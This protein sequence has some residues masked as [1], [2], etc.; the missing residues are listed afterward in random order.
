[1][2]QIKGNSPI[3]AGKDLIKLRGVLYVVYNKG[4]TCA[5]M[6][7]RCLS[8]HVKPRY[9]ALLV[10]ARC[11]KMKSMTALKNNSEIQTLIES[12]PEK[13]NV[14]LASLFSSPHPSDHSVWISREGDVTIESADDHFTNTYVYHSDA[15]DNFEKFIDALVP[16]LSQ[17]VA[18]LESVQYF[19][20]ELNS[21]NITAYSHPFLGSYDLLLHRSSSGFALLGN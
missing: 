11:D 16:R 10:Y 15:E 7:P 20:R 2:L 13:E 3:Y 5:F 21:I 1:M 14:S 4:V 17:V 18:A 6:F 19:S 9:C 12:L 8:C